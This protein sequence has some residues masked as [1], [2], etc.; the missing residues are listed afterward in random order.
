[1]GIPNWRLIGLTCQAQKRKKRVT[2]NAGL[3]P[4][5]GMDCYS[6]KLQRAAQVRGTLGGRPSGC[7]GVAAR[8]KSLESRSLRPEIKDVFIP[9]LL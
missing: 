3:I 4:M 2:A 9:K 1:M 5:L 6:L 8:P 7:E